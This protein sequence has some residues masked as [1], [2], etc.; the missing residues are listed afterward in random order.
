M[1][2]ASASSGAGSWVVYGVPPFD[3]VEYVVFSVKN[4]FFGCMIFR[5]HFVAHAEVSV[6][7]TGKAFA[8]NVTVLIAVPVFDKL[9]K[10]SIA[11]FYAG[12]FEA[13]LV[14]VRKKL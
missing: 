1:V 5:K 8:D 13:V 2:F 3:T 10:A 7:G 11:V 14:R 6:A 12:A 4:V 9:G